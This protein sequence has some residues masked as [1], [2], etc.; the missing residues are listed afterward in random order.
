[1]ARAPVAVFVAP[2]RVPAKARLRATVRE[3]G[4]IVESLPEPVC[5]AVEATGLLNQWRQQLETLA[6]ATRN[7]GTLP[8]A[9]ETARR[10]WSALR[11]R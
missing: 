5:A 7:L 3:I 11:G 1:M 4:R 10:A 8:G 9:V 6:N 2:V